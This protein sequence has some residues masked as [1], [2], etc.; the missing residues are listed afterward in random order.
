[1]TI[2]WRELGVAFLLAISLWYLVTGSEKIETQIDVRLD[3]KGIP[4]NLI[5]REGLVTKVAVRVRATAGVARAMYGREYM[6]SMNLSS[7]VKGE[8]TLPVPV[9]QLP[10]LGGVEVIDITPPSITLVVDAIE[11]KSVPLKLEFHSALSQDYTAKATLEPDLVTL[12]GPS[13]ALLGI[14]SVK[15]PFIVDGEPLE[16]DSLLSKDIPLPEGIE[17]TPSKVQV[18]LTVK[19]NR[20]RMEFDVPVTLIDQTGGYDSTTRR[21]RIVADVPLSIAT[22]KDLR[23]VVQAEATVPS[24]ISQNPLVPVV[25]RMPLSCNLVQVE[26]KSL[27]LTQKREG[28][29]D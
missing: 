6:Y 27:K 18:A 26:P 5:V 2:R 29:V 7:L 17:A 24:D 28:E 3:Y 8:N 1:M 20:K 9:S 4:A 10:F 22:A 15:L 19:I 25:V 16:G 12:K 11:T 23:E 13:Q 14:Q 21:V